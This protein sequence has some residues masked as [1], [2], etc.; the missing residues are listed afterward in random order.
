MSVYYSIK[1]VDLG[2]QQHWQGPLQQLVLAMPTGLDVHQLGTARM[3][4]ASMV[5]SIIVPMLANSGS[6]A[7]LDQLQRLHDWV[8][9][10]LRVGLFL[11]VVKHFVNTTYFSLLGVAATWQGA[12]Q[13]QA[14]CIIH[15]IGHPRHR[16][17]R[18][19]E[20][21]VLV[22][23]SATQHSPMNTTPL[24]S[25]LRWPSSRLSNLTTTGT[26]QRAGQG[27]M[28][29][30]NHR[31]TSTLQRCSNASRGHVGS[32]NRWSTALFK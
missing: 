20:P 7:D 6:G 4:V 10:N 31:K 32:S 5:G 14:L 3:A 2:Q 23:A 9:I 8:G 25:A 13:Q 19:Q 1:Q 12:M 24:A 29:G 28:A 26:K 11:G 17:E 16:A 27:P 21:V 15:T 18:W 30:A 22:A